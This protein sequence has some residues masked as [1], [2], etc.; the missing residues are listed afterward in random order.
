MC[1]SN[2]EISSP[3]SNC[4][5]SYSYKHQVLLLF[6]CNKEVLMLH[7]M[8]AVELSTYHTWEIIGN[9]CWQFEVIF[10][11]IFQEVDL[12]DSK[13]WTALIS[14]LGGEEGKIFQVIENVILMWYN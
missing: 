3:A 9:L 1:K 7:K 14:Q 13:M 5:D 6:C 10:T 4:D 11:M 8:T 2:I 12:I